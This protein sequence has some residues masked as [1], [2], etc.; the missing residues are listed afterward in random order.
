MS[1]EAEKEMAIWFIINHF[2]D[3]YQNRAILAVFERREL[4]IAFS[5]WKPKYY[6]LMQQKKKYK[7]IKDICLDV[8]K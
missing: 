6:Q 8:L 2:S 1:V 7:H 3:F 5:T 4:N